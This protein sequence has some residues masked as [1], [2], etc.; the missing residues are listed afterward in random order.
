[1][2]APSHLVDLAERRL[3]ILLHLFVSA[4]L[5]THQKSAKTR[6]QKTKHGALG[7]SNSNKIFRYKVFEGDKEHTSEVILPISTILI[8]K[9]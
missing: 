1:M 9:Y 2:T 6:S 8:S 5:E 7:K 3:F 4:D